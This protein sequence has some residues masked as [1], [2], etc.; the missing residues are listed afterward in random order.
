MQTKQESKEN[1]LIHLYIYKN[2]RNE[3]IYVYYIIY[4]FIHYTSRKANKKLAIERIM[5]GFRET[6]LQKYIAKE[7]DNMGTFT[8]MQKRKMAGIQFTYAST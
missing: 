8:T 4:I 2:E 5:K 7:L 1:I 3:I 6:I